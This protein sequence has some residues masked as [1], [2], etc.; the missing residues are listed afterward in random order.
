MEMQMRIHVEEFEFDGAGYKLKIFMDDKFRPYKIEFSNKDGFKIKSPFGLD[1]EFV[2][3]DLVNNCVMDYLRVSKLL[4][5]IGYPHDAIESAKRYLSNKPEHPGC[6]AAVLSAAYRQV[7]QPL[8]AI[9]STASYVHLGS[10]ALHS[11]RAGAHMDL[12][13]LDGETNCFELA[14]AELKTSWAIDP[15]EECSLGYKRLKSLAPWLFS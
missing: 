4:R 7:K 3:L 1:G 13:E 12:G 15:S 6:G 5:E 9:M 11:S 8:K 14:L 10:S 2:L